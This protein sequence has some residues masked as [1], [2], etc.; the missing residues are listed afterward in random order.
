[1]AL[2]KVPSR[3]AQEKS[4]NPQGGAH[5]TPDGNSTRRR[6]PV[7]RAKISVRQENELDLQEIAAAF[8]LS[9]PVLLG[10]FDP[11]GSCVRTCQASLLCQEQ[12]EPLSGSWPD[13][14]MWDLTSV[15]ELRT[16]ERPT[17]GRES[18]LWPTAQ[19]HD[20]QGAKTPDQIE[21][22]RLKGHGVSNLNESA[23]NW[24]T[25]QARDEKNANLIGSG[26]YQRKLDAG[27]TIDLND[28]AVNWQTPA[29]DSFR[30]RG[31]DRKD[32]MGLDQQG[33]K[34]QTPNSRDWKS[35]VGSENN[36][37][38][39]TPN[40]SRQVYRH[41][42]PDPTIPDGPRS[43]GSGQTLRR[44]L[45]PRFVEWLMGFPPCWTELKD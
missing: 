26:N 13:S 22:M 3:L 4:G 12:W 34:W 45:N 39:K 5:G 21:A 42:L 44:R 35:E 23:A 14:A 8:G 7:S 15:Y 27:F 33:R 31:G 25:P 38:D 19:A 36:T 1:M 32:E 41:S 17:S 18:S 2:S 10:K 29:T 37:H 43:S 6:V 24:P 28:K 20:A 16:S 9:S 40:L 30:S 11:D